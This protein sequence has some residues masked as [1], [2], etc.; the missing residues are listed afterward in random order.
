LI[1]TIYECN[2]KL[3]IP[4]LIDQHIHITGGG[5]EKGP[6][7]RITE[8]ASEEVLQ[9]GVTTLVGVLGADSYTRSLE[10]LLAKAKGLEAQGVTTYIYTGS[11]AIPPVTFTGSVARD[12]VNIE[13]VIGVGELAISDHRSTIP[14]TIPLPK[15]VPRPI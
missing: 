5:G 9:A 10:N 6:A 7:S 12:L 3:A 8:I 14:I 2:G 4:G 1:D 11:Y 15:F 13:K